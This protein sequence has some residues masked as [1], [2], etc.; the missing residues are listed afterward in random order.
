M[1]GRNHNPT[2]EGGIWW[3]L[4]YAFEI[5]RC[6]S[7]EGDIAIAGVVRHRILCQFNIQSPEGDTV[8]G[9][10][11]SVSPAGLF[12]NEA[13]LSGALRH[14]QGLCRPLG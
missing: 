4:A 6:F 2:R 10:T 12:V 14:R 8:S 3:H 7:P 9:S 11:N 13:S 1:V 5:A